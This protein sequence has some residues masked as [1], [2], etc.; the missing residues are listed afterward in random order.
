[1]DRDITLE[2]NNKTMFHTLKA[3]AKLKYEYFPF[4]FTSGQH[5]IN[6]CKKFQIARK[7]GMN[8][9]KKNMACI[10]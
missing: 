9:R 2:L 7:F 6:I 5:C 1:M 8:L 3:S 4:F 10:I